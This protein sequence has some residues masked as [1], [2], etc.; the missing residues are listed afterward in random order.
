MEGEKKSCHWAVVQPRGDVNNLK[1]EEAFRRDI[2]K[3]SAFWEWRLSH[4]H[5]PNM[6]RFTLLKAVTADEY[7]KDK[8]FLKYIFRIEEED[9]KEPRYIRCYDP[10]EPNAY[11]AN[12]QG[13]QLPG[14]P[15]T[16][17]SWVDAGPR[18]RC[19]YGYR[20]SIM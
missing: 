6:Y 9:G 18:C 12:E 10:K 11:V 4:R 13:I 2:M 3:D 20:S 16:M 8:D 14:K 7:F 19:A 5:N 17:R 1:K 15:E